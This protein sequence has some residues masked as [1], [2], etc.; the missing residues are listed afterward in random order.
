MSGASIYNTQAQDRDNDP[1]QVVS[2]MYGGRF[3]TV[4]FSRA[5]RS[6]HGVSG[7]TLSMPWVPRVV[8]SVRRSTR[9]AVQRC[10]ALV[11]GSGTFG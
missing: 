9:P 4:R 1:V 8:P 11:S 7:Q 6:R 10:G 2:Q 5:A 3:V